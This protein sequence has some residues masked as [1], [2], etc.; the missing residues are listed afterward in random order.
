MYAGLGELLRSL[1]NSTARNVIWKLGSRFYGFS[2]VSF[3]DD[4]VR[5]SK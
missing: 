2:S 4:F 3:V 5:S 1:S